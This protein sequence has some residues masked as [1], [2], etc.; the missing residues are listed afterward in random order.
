[1][2]YKQPTDTQSVQCIID[3]LQ[4]AARQ[5]LTQRHELPADPANH[6]QAKG[7][8]K[9]A[10]T[11]ALFD[12]I[13][14]ELG[15][16]KTIT[17]Q[18]LLKQRAD[19]AVLQPL[20]KAISLW[21]RRPGVKAL[22]EF[23]VLKAE[24]D[25]CLDTATIRRSQLLEDEAKA[26]SSLTKDKFPEAKPAILMQLLQ[27]LHSLQEDVM[28]Q[29]DMTHCIQAAASHSRWTLD[30]FA[31]GS[32]SFQGWLRI[33]QHPLVQ[34][35]ILTALSHGKHFQVW[36][37]SIGWL[38][39]YAALTYGLQ[40]VG[41]ELLSCHVDTAQQLASHFQV[42]APC[43]QWLGQLSKRLSGATMQHKCYV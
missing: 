15:M 42:G 33:F 5:C 4:L 35:H 8:M 38:V 12:V 40:A 39:F 11:T 27:K 24:P 31:Y 9:G 7:A 23:G 10:N 43:A 6:M 19:S 32:T 17:M 34:P 36:G 2:S 30:N 26:V 21:K 29:A 22:L 20:Q 14:Q 16:L 3:E 41:Y 37:S 25:C 1:M 28:F 13:M 18:A